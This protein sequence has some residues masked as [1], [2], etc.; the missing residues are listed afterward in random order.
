[1]DTPYEKGSPKE[2]T[3]RPLYS[4]MGCATPRE[5]FISDNALG[6]ATPRERYISDNSSKI[7]FIFKMLT[8]S[9]QLRVRR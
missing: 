8:L 2:G 7:N 1:V 4:G 3:E 5:R 6:Y 9:N